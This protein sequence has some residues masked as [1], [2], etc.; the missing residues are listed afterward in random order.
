[1]NSPHPAWA[2]AHKRKGT[3]LKR[4]NGRYYLYEV[5]SKWNPEKKRAV[6]IT[7]RILGNITEEKGFVE[8]DKTR[9]RK[10]NEF[11]GK[12]QVKEY[13][14]TAAIETL[15]AETVEPLK[16]HFPETWP[17][18]VC[19]AYGRLVHQAPLKNMAAHT[20][21]SFLSERHP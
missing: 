3:E 7:G 15:F 17:T 13:G 4:I 1:M 5:S 8:S 11:A 2:T 19:L 16:K 21:A 6:K 10:Q 12:I 18:L 14:I 9:L 20:A